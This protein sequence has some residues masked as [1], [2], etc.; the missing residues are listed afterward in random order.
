MADMDGMVGMDG[1]VGTC[2]EHP[3]GS[4][5]PPDLAYPP[6]LWILR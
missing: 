6:V 4:E 2:V 1:I 5:C 3:Q